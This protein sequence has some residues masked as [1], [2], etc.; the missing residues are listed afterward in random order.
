MLR[1]YWFGG[2]KVRSV[3]LVSLGLK[4]G[5]SVFIG[6]N[7]LDHW[8]LDWSKWLSVG[9]NEV[10]S[11]DQF[12]YDRHKYLLDH[13]KPFWS[14]LPANAMPEPHA[15]AYR[16]TKCTKAKWFPVLLHIKYIIF[17]YQHYVVAQWWA[18]WPQEL[19]V[20][21]LQGRRR[22]S[23]GPASAGPLFWPSMLSAVPLFFFSAF[24]V[25]FTLCLWN[26]LIALSKVPLIPVLLIQLSITLVA[27]F[28]FK[29]VQG[30]KTKQSHIVLN[31]AIIITPV[32]FNSLSLK[33]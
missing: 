23:A 33:D 14:N 7:H 18:H 6:P 20:P 28:T 9:P 8:T 1:K 21:G 32:W 3:F 17:I 12:Q 26:C 5:V 30:V 13:I 15:P 31:T 24:S 11:L 4:T 27:R 16:S 22:R 2:A 25:V 29:P 10:Y 19:K